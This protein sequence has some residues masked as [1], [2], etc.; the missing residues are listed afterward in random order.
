MITFEKGMDYR[1]REAAAPTVARFNM[2]DGTY[3]YVVIGTA[4]GYIRRNSGDV[5][6]WGSYSG[7]R[8]YARK[9]A[10]VHGL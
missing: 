8:R 9:Y 7:A 4:Y 6:T 10:V 5:Y 1:C 2:G 3:R